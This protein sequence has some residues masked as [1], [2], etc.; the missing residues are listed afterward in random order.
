[1]T[2]TWSCPISSQDSWEISFL[3]WGLNTP[4]CLVPASCLFPEDADKW[5]APCQSFPKPPAAA[6]GHEHVFPSPAL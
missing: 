5:R 4:V 3:D 2:G 1:M 6:P